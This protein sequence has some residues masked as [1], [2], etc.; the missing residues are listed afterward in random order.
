[1]NIAY[2][3]EFEVV[4]AALDRNVAVVSCHS[5]QADHY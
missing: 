2:F 3:E 5:N 1:V 4:E